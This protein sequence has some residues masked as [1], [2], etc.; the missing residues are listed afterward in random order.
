[1]A[2]NVQEAIS[3]K[4]LKNLYLFRIF[5][6]KFVF[7]PNTLVSLQVDDELW[8]VLTYSKRISNAMSNGDLA[9]R[10]NT[11]LSKSK[12]KS[13]LKEL[14]QLKDE[15]Q[16]FVDL[17]PSPVMGCNWQIGYAVLQ[18]SHACNL[19][20]R[21]C[22][23][24]GGAYGGKPVLMSAETARK[25]GDFL[26]DQFGSN[27]FSIGFFGGEPLMNFEVIREVV[28]HTRQKASER[29]KMSSFHLTT[30]GVLL[31]KDVAKFLIENNFS[32]I[33]SIDGPREVHDQMRIF[34]NGKGSFDIVLKNLQN[35]KG[36]S[37]I[38]ST[39]LRSTYSNVNPMLRKRVLFLSKLAQ[40]GFAS[41][42]SV[43]PACLSHQACGTT[44]PE[45]MLTADSLK[46]LKPQYSDMAKV[47]VRKVKEGKPL[48]FF[49]FTLMLKRLV[50]RK[51]QERECRAGIGYVVVNPF[52]E[53]YACHREGES[54]IGD[55]QN[56]YDEF[57][58]RG[59]LSNSLYER[60]ICCTCWARFI[61]GGGCRINAI[62]INNDVSEPW[63]VE[64]R[65]RQHW[66]RLCIWILSELT[67]EEIKSALNSQM[68]HD[69]TN[70]QSN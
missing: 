32:L 13:I 7:D 54:K 60:A 51:R 56:G 64:C 37:L 10:L 66:I 65:L 20:C 38:K 33:V 44:N 43:E 58:R 49:H 23:A 40:E 59:W 35:I 53:L 47:F 41:N 5:G 28:R 26:I 19:N 34:D 16:L 50:E 6:K 48:P 14:Q 4:D 69:F 63:D 8:S 2:N 30:N 52:G 3:L 57:L 12:I 42:I 45:M 39:I 67:E 55:L 29:G 17:P 62:E 36:T 1:M 22:F 46:M 9:G 68:P 24:G 18:I 31:T 70:R 15:K 61:C 27:D 25:A 11:K 21:Y